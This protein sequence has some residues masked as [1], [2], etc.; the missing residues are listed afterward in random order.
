MIEFPVEKLMTL[1]L[2]KLLVLEKGKYRIASFN[3]SP[4]LSKFHF[5]L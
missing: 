5:F 2:V 1:E 3:L 4:L